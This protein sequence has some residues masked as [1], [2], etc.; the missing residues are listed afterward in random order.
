MFGI[1]MGELLVILGIVV[2]LFGTKRL[3]TLGADL[4]SAIKGFRS[5]VKEE[6][7]APAPR[8]RVIEGEIGEHRVPQTHANRTRMFDISFPELVVVCVIALLVTGPGTPAGRAAHARFVGGPDVADVQRDENRDRTRNRHG[9]NSPPTA[10]RS[11]DGSRSSASNATFAAKPPTA[12]T[13][14]RIR[15]IAEVKAPDTAP[16]SATCGRACA[17]CGNP[18]RAT[19]RLNRWQLS[20]RKPNRA[21]EHDVAGRLR[22]TAV[23]RSHHRTA[24]TPAESAARGAAAVLPAVLLRQRHLRVGRR[25]ADVEPAGRQRHDCDRS[26]LALS[27]AVQVVDVRCVFPRDAGDPSPDVGV[28]FA[29]LY[30]AR[31][32][33]RV[34]AARFQ[35]HSLLPRHGVCVLPRVPAGIQ[36]LR[37]RH[38]GR[39]RR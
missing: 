38:A 35:R 20:R 18:R 5:A 15:R 8:E 31:E 28:R 6:E 36:I 12:R 33:L 34:T 30:T 9:R 37:G 29:G 26:R 27:D 21:E 22:R 11:G 19:A 17:G 24:R 3:K 14:H 16:R 1:G 32:A 23:P 4:G 2:L 25:A 39:R 10:Q 13:I 7:S